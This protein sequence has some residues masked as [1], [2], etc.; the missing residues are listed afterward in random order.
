MKKCLKNK[1]RERENDSACDLVCA[2]AQRFCIYI[3]IIL[4]NLFSYLVVAYPPI[5]QFAHADSY[6]FTK[7]LAR[8]MVAYALF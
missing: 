2:S 6:T 1:E 7:S 3:L 5:H 8:I 4:S